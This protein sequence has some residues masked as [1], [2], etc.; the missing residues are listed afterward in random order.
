MKFGKVLTPE[1]ALKEW[2]VPL[3]GELVITPQSSSKSKT[4]RQSK[5]Q[6][7]ENGQKRQENLPQSEESNLATNEEPPRDDDPNRPETEEDAIR[8]EAIRRLRV[9]HLAKGRPDQT[10]NS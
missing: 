6:P 9:L 10:K 4:S 1:E 5:N 8:A 2:G 7:S 3:E